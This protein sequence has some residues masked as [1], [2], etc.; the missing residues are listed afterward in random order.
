MKEINAQIDVF[1]TNGITFEDISTIRNAFKEYK[2]LVDSISD[3]EVEE[4]RELIVELKDKFQ[5][6]F[7]SIQ[8]LEKIQMEANEE[9][10]KV[11]IEL[12]N[13]KKNI[14]DQLIDLIQNEKEISKAFVTFNALKEEWGKIEGQ[15]KDLDKKYGKLVEDFYYHINMYRAIQDHDFKK[16]QQLKFQL[17]NRL[18]V[19]LEVKV[20]SNILPQLKQ[21][22][23]EWQTI[24]PVGKEMK[25]TIWN[26][27]IKLSDEVFALHLKIKEEESAKIESLILAKKQLIDAAKFAI[28]EVPNTVNNWKIKTN[29]MIDL[30]NQWRNIGEL[31]S[32][33]NQPLFSTFRKIMDSFFKQKDE[34]FASLKNKTDEFVQVKKDLIEQ[35][36]SLISQENQEEVAKKII[37]IQR[38]WKDS[39]SLPPKLEK[40]LWEEFKGVCDS[41]FKKKEEERRVLKEKQNKESNEKYAII[42][43]INTDL[44]N[45]ELLEII[46]K[47]FQT[48][49]QSTSFTIKNDLLFDEKIF[50]WA[51]NQKNRVQAEQEIFN[52]YK[53][54]LTKDVLVLAEVKFVIKQWLNKGLESKSLLENNLAFFGKSNSPMLTSMKLNIELLDKKNQL[55]NYLL[56][57]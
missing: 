53:N 17:I 4:V 31:P 38:K 43:L 37:E 48:L 40:K 21:I 32:K 9:K 54:H 8:E 22:Q 2:K 30:Q 39:G 42:K 41:F 26:E 10:G 51:G 1:F 34:Y 49:S 23:K 15:D 44:S 46:K 5:S 20:S 56:K 29:L 57:G 12:R 25:E 52:V 33:I 3:D 45:E 55:L 7:S 50:E 18:K 36:K 47:Y 13:A 6:L 19:L 16:N 27:Y 35:V 24:G 14:V 11:K 28:E